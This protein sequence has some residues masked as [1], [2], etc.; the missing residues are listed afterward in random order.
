MYA[1][2]TAVFLMSAT[3][4]P[5][6]QDTQQDIGQSNGSQLSS[7]DGPVQSLSP[8]IM[9]GELTLGRKSFEDLFDTQFAIR[10]WFDFLHRCR[11][12]SL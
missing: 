2:E 3:P 9:K 6:Q 1:E 10:S 5:D 8:A 4:V 11:K 12:K 7:E